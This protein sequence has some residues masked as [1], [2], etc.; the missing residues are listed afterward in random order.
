MERFSAGQRRIPIELSFGPDLN[1]EGTVFRLWAPSA[2]R[3]ELVIH[4]GIPKSD[5]EDGIRAGTAIELHPDKDGWCRSERL[6]LGAGTRYRYRIDDQLEVPDPASRFQPEGVHGASEVVDLARFPGVSGPAVRGV[7][8]EET[9]LYE[10]HVGT[11]SPEGSFAGVGERLEYLHTLGVNA[12][13]L[14]PIAAFAGARNWGYDGVLPYAPASAYGTPEDLSQLIRSAHRTGITLF[15]DV[16]YNHFGPEGNYLHLYAKPFFTERFHTPWGA[17]I[18]FSLPEVRA[19][20]L[21]NALYWTEL[22]GFDGLRLDAVHAIRDGSS[23]HIVDAIAR[24]VREVA[25]QNTPGRQVHV[26]LENEEND[27]NRL[28]AAT[29]Q[30]NDDL[31]HLIHVLLTGESEGY[32]RDYREEPHRALGKTLAEGFYFQGQAAGTRGGAPRGTSS[33]DLSPTALVGFSHNHDQIGNRAFGERLTALS[34]ESALRAAEALVL[35]SPQVP[36]LFMGEEWGSKT[37]FLF[38]C[39]FQGELADAVREGRRREFAG[40]TAFKNEAIRRRIP[41]PNA[42]DTFQAC[43][44]GWHRRSEEGGAS[45]AVDRPHGDSVGVSPS[46]DEQE[47]TDCRMRHRL[48]QRLLELR[49]EWLQPRLSTLRSGSYEGAPDEA[50]RVRWLGA[51]ERYWTIYFNLTSVGR[52][53]PDYAPPE[54]FTL[55]YSDGSGGATDPVP[56]GTVAPWTVV[57]A[58]EEDHDGE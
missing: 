10:L 25:L 42:V 9:V 37:P 38:F 12:V 48:T 4:R 16:V 32:Y 18:D 54:S 35:L 51:K 36:M 23:E 20:F 27:A 2:G 13:E 55:I 24:H 21:E 8:W 44:L 57:V 50:M 17:A 34:N 28:E 19:F 29:A 33:R 41:D 22:Y 43:R 52:R 49:R 3:V 58:I 30:W 39:D 45:N 7:P 47:Y 14:M 6:P 56:G 53:L 40:F 15:L 31:H 26:V 5:G 46:P 11:F 1:A